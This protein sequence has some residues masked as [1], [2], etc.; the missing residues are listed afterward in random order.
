V[1]KRWQ[2]QDVEPTA[3]GWY[4][5]ER[6]D[7]TTCVR[8][9]GGG[10]WWIPLKDGWLSGLPP[11]FRWRGPVSSFGSDQ[12]RSPWE[13]CQEVGARLGLTP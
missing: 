1:G 12:N 4:E 11:G 5:V 8:A 2:G 6:E 9:F 7:G 3:V 10:S 13:E